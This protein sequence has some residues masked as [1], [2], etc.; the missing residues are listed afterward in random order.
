MDFQDFEIGDLIDRGT[1]SK[2]YKVSH[3]ITKNDLAVK[4]YNKDL[5]KKTKRYD[6]EENKYCDY[7]YV[8][9]KEINFFDIVKKDKDYDKYIIKYYGYQETKK[10]VYL[11]LELSKKKQLMIF[12]NETNIYSFTNN[13][14]NNII[15]LKSCM[16][17]MLESINYIHKKNIVHLDIKI[18]NFL[19]FDYKEKIRVKLIDFNSYKFFEK[20]KDN[21]LTNKYGTFLY[22]S[23]ECNFDMEK[24]YCPLKA[25]IWALGICFYVMLKNNLPFIIED[26]NLNYE[27]AY[28][29]ATKNQIPNFDDIDEDFKEVIC[30][31]LCKNPCERKDIPELLNFKLFN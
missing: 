17:N 21:L 31:M 4:V 10:K 20:E 25:D 2:I 24:G 23:P 29:V 7:L 15:F 9:K 16:K 1:F 14:Y 19:L 30:N 5:L 18:E 26:E 11:F 27:F 13:S 22:T 6:F 12:N 8:I 28:S 3:K